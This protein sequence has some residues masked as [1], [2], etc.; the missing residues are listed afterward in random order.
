M[1]DD[2]SS[3]YQKEEEY[4]ID[5]SLEISIGEIPYLGKIFGIF[6]A[7]KNKN[8]LLYFLG[9]LISLI[10]TWLQVVAQGWLVLQLTN[11]A[12]LLGLVTAISTL[13]T[14]IFSLHGGVIVDR[15]PKRKILIFTQTSSMILAFA[16]GILTVLK[17]INVGEILILSFL[18]GLVTAVDAP[19]RQAFVPEMVGKEKL[20]SAIALNSGVFNAARVIGPA[21]AGFLIVIVGTGGAFILNGISYIAV[22]AALFAMTVPSIVGKN[23]LNPTAAIKEGLS[24]SF[25][26]P[27]IRSLL[28]LISVVSVFGWSY[29]TILPYIAQDIYHMGAAGLGYLY[30]AAGLGALAATVIVSATLKKISPTVYIFGGNFL[31]AVSIFL[32]SLNINFILS[33]AFLFFA[34]FGLLIQVTALNTT[35]QNMVPHEIRGRVMSIYVLMFIGTSPIG[36]FEIGW[37][38]DKMGTSFAIQAG[39]IVVFVFGL[40]MFFRRNKILEQYKLY[41]E[42]TS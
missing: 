9:Q 32:F 39:A 5:E 15:F 36:S 37:L 10:G 17:I 25:G 19:A 30:A 20:P 14:L 7:L 8:Y 2:S 27:I 12:F 34:G 4:I 18:L 38:S 40:F 11:S 29:S 3:N 28:I 42:N 13:P 35:I 31:F 41:R 24:Y 33:L 22:I 23:K 1:A 16:L 21:V 6:P 26:H